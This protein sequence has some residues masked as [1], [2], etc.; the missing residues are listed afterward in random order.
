MRIVTTTLLLALSAP[1]MAQP[2]ALT[3]APVPSIDSGNVTP[4]LR[5]GE[6][7][8]SANQA[9]FSAQPNNMIPGGGQ[10]TPQTLGTPSDRES[11]GVPA[12][13]K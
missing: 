4:A 10:P 13:T 1:V 9:P 12:V 6:S 7:N 5:A 8:T 11:A 3:P 2:G